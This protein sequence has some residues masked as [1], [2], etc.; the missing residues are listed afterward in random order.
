MSSQ[1][2]SHETEKILNVQNNPSL[3]K[4]LKRKKRNLN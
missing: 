1:T 2:H 3:L 4:N